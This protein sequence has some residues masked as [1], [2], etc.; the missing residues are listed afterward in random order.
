[1]FF[2]F[3]FNAEAFSQKKK[4][5][6][7]QVGEIVD[8]LIPNLQQHIKILA[9][10]SLEGR[11]TGTVG[12]QLAAN[13]IKNE[14]IKIGLNAKGENGGFFQTFEVNEGKEFEQYST[15]YFNDN[16]LQPTLDYFP[17]NISAN[18]NL[19][20]VVSP[21]LKDINTTWFFDLNEDLIKN[22]KNP[23]YDIS[24]FIN[25]KVK[26]LAAFG[27]KGLILYNSSTK[28]LDNQAFDKKLKIETEKIPVI[29][30]T[31][32]G[33]KKYIK[34]KDAVVEMKCTVEIKDKKR[35]GTNV[36]AYINNNAANT[37]IIGAHY[38]HLGYGE[39]KNSLYAGKEKMIH[40]G[41]DDNAS[42]VAALIETA[43][44]LKASSAK[45]N[46][47]L[48]ITFSGEELGLFGSKYYTEHP[49]IDLATAN[50]MVNMDMV[51][52]L[53]DSTQTFTIGGYGTSPTWG[54]II[55]ETDKWNTLKVKFDSS[56]SG[57]SDHTS[58]YKKNIP[59]L[60]FFTGTHSDYH[61]PTDD[62]DKI[63]FGGE[64]KIVQYLSK[65]IQATDPLPKLTFTKTKENATG[66]SSTR[67]T[68]S[69]GIMP[70]YTYGGTGVRADGISEGKLAQRLGLKTGDVLTKL[71]DFKITSVENYMQVLSKFKKGDST[72]LITTREG[73]E[74]S[75]D[76][77]F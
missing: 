58:F 7:K 29:Y 48:F 31:K 71:G 9:S 46:N 24:P 69:L 42:G 38:D 54:E 19:N 2:A 8:N 67:F 53:N 16:Y 59:V 77:T 66:G 74:V 14:F 33:F 72:K 49:T 70:D 37:I 35:V 76:I 73:K 43:R 32:E 39:D 34:T 68:V 63:N 47:Y 50:Y 36:I 25:K 75:Y 62:Y 30:L 22:Q 5:I 11:R 27:V 17:L 61:K 56:G 64:E 3:I 23:H 41:A 52:R 45:K 40:N 20:E 28:L 55:K 15:L 51:G 18:G 26:E 65:I 13:Y 60:F 44:K 10:D 21:I 6:K 1:M 12:E 4:K 57:P